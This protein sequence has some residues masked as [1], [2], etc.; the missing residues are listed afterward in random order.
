M[1]CHW[2]SRGGNPPFE[3]DMPLPTQLHRAIPSPLLKIWCLPDQEGDAV[4]EVAICPEQVSQVHL[5]T[6]AYWQHC[7]NPLL[8]LDRQKHPYSR[9]SALKREFEFV[10][11]TFLLRQWAITCSDGF[12]KGVSASWTRK[13]IKFSCLFVGEQLWG[14]PLPIG[15]KH[16]EHTWM[17]LGVGLIFCS[18]FTVLSNGV[19]PSNS[20]YITTT[21]CTGMSDWFKAAQFL[22]IKHFY[23]SGE[24]AFFVKFQ[25]S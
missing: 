8:S 7:H 19:G 17:F 4:L 2:I 20:A 24:V 13:L 3:H 10:S 21:V 16:L 15:H 14:L 25:N 12:C 22:I 11:E 9:F 6:L 1:R 23:C 5:Q 18:R